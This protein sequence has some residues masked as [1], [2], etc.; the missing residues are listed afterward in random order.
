MLLRRR[1][2]DWR[3]PLLVGS[4]MRLGLPLG[5]GLGRGWK[6]LCLLIEVFESTIG[7]FTIALVIL[8][9]SKFSVISLF[10]LFNKERSRCLVEILNRRI[11]NFVHKLCLPEV[12]L[13]LRWRR[14]LLVWS[15]GSVYTL[16]SNLIV[17]NNRIQLNYLIGKT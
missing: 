6:R 3:L 5:R 8:M 17:I 13:V 12:K 10:N 2:L 4:L 11:I 9:T 16:H 7:S 15:F 1:T 14:T